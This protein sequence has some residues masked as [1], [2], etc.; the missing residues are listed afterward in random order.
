MKR[1]VLAVVSYLNAKPLIE[2][3]SDSF[4]LVEA[5]PAEC[6]NLVRSGRADL[7]LIP[8]IGLGEDTSLAIVPGIA[9]AAEGPVRSVLLVTRGPVESL[10]SVAVDESSRAAAALLRVLCARRFGVS[11]RFAAAP[12]DWQAMLDEHDAA[13]LIGDPALALANDER[14]RTR[15]DLQLIDIGD[16]WTRWTRLPFVFAVWAG[17]MDR[18]TPEIVAALQ[19][20]RARGLTRLEDIARAAARDPAQSAGNLSY[21]RQSIRYELAA[22]ELAGLRRF[23]DLAGELGLL[24][25]GRRA[26]IELTFAEVAPAEPLIDGR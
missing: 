6:W 19:S 5:V 4:D 10:R 8:A 17:R 23:L 22:R 20:A 9:I 2:G 12:P 24:A 26:P 21:L 13:L 14:F 18:V 25:G 16:E 11:P 3:L 1:P 15:R 7:G